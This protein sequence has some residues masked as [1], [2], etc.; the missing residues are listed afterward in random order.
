LRLEPILRALAE[1]RN[2][3]RIL[4]T[5]N[6]SDFIDEG[7]SILVTVQDSEGVE[8]QYRCQYLIGADGGRFVGPKIGVEMEGPKGITDMVSIYFKADLSEYWD[9]RFFACH[10]INGSCVTVFESGALVPLGPTWGRYSEEWVIH[11]GFDLDDESRFDEDK[12]KPRVRALLK[13]P[14]L[15]IKVLRTSHW[16]IER[17]LASKY[18]EG[19]VFLA[20]DAAHRRPPTT[21]LGLNTSIEDSLNLAW[22]LALVLKQKAEP[23]ILDT[24]ESERRPI[25]RRNCDWGLFTFKNSNVINAAVGLVPGQEEANKLSFAQLFEDSEIGRSRRAQVGLI[26]DSQCI[27]FSAHDIELGFRYDDGFHVP[28]GTDAPES[29]PYGQIYLPTT[30]PGHRLPHAW[31]EKY[32]VVISTHDLV[33]PEG[34]FLVITD[35]YGS[36]WVSIAEKCAT[37][38]NIKITTAQI[39]PRSANPTNVTDHDEQW[40]KVKCLERGGAL[41]VRPDNF[42]AWRSRSASKTGGSELAIA[43]NSL[44]DNK[45]AGMNNC[46]NRRL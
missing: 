23:A 1:H 20:G 17:V 8:T 12:L 45:D 3:R 18:S 15:D 25:G 11:F 29:D 19:R 22:K 32:N 5:H 4:F 7:Q 21:G 28:D 6:V 37:A 16:I 24:Y 34:A 44:L 14:N 10:F 26:I 39:G 2:P 27:E 42:V 43:I 9:D 35:S 36:D 46:T 40:E 31:V 38:C 41:L 33:G 30:R 13:L